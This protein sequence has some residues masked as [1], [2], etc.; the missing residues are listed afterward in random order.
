MSDLERFCED[1]HQDILTE[2]SAAPAGALQA[3]VYTRRMIDYLTE[4]GE[5]DDGEVVYHRARGVEA[6]GYSLDEDLE[7]LNLFVSHFTQQCPPISVTKAEVDTAFRRLRTFLERCGDAYAA[8]LEIASPSRD[9]A[10]AVAEAVRRRFDVRLFLFTDGTISR[11]VSPPRPN[12]EGIAAYEIW[13]LE[14]LFRCVSSG[15]GRESVEIDF[16]EIN[17]GPVPCLRAGGAPT[18]YDAYLLILPGNVLNAIYERYGPRVLELNVS[19]VPSGP[20]EGQ[21]GHQRH[22]P[23]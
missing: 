17:G 14:R 9:M 19:V 7:Q 10:L 3:E 15:R 6:S 11:G 21:Q 18:E 2:A 20:R 5:L 16:E 22:Y 13:D 8:D 23:A 12:G 1:L 4:A